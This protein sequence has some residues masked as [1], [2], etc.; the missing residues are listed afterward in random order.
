M[1]ESAFLDDLEL[2]KS[3]FGGANEAQICADA[4]RNRFGPSSLTM[5]DVGS[6]RGKSTIEMVLYLRGFGFEIRPMFIEPS[7]S[8][9]DRET[10]LEYGGFFE[11]GFEEYE[12]KGQHDVV[13]ST[14]SIY[15]LGEPESAL[16][17]L[18]SCV[19]SGGLLLVTS[20]SERCVF[21]RLYERLYRNVS[22]VTSIETLGAIVGG[23]GIDVEIQYSQ[24]SVNLAMWKGNTEM[25]GA[26][27]RVI[28][29][30]NRKAYVSQVQELETLL[31]E[32]QDLEVRVNGTMIAR[33]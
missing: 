23:L 9:L 8:P 6:G 25:L 12:C 5:I 18:M 10:F 29:R 31:N 2:M 4:I 26:V 20:W 22:A 16:R 13:K 11:G 30:S 15:Y 3:S 7:A 28:S 14:Q 17:G 32:F 1:T 19:A 21:Y 24:G 27:D 33:T